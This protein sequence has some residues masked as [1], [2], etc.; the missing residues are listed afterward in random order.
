MIFTIITILVAIIFFISSIKDEHNTILESIFFSLISGI[1][2]FILLL[3]VSGIITDLGIQKEKIILFENKISVVNIDNKDY[4]MLTCN[5]DNKKVYKIN[6]E[7][8]Q[9]II[10]IE[11]FEDEI[12]RYNSTENKIVKYQMQPKN[13]FLNNLIF[14]FVINNEYEIYIP[15]DSILEVNQ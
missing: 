9:E 8:E 5:K 2:I 13:N 3:I 12:E 15:E 10:P 11:L 4:T 1:I 6:I 7:T 14:K